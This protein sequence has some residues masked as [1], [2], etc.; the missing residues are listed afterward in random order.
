MQQSLSFLCHIYPCVVV[1]FITITVLLV[2]NLYRKL[3]RTDKVF[4]VIA[5]EYIHYIG[6]NKFVLQRSRL[7]K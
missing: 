2:A 1:C 3:Y 5:S 6:K 4:F 7:M